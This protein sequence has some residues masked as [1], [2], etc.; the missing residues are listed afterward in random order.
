MLKKRKAY[1]IINSGKSVAIKQTKN[2]GI[3]MTVATFM[4]FHVSITRTGIDE[5]GKPIYKYVI[6]TPDR[7]RFEN[8]FS[9]SVEGV[10]KIEF[11]IIEVLQWVCLEYGNNDSSLFQR[12]NTLQMEFAKS[13][14][15]AEY[16]MYLDDAEE[17]LRKETYA[18]YYMD[19]NAFTRI[20][21]FKE[22][23]TPLVILSTK[24]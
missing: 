5:Y 4:N 7:T 8:Q 17:F 15:C 22:I 18:A 9:P 16:S 14:E 3:I 12:Y 24:D 11:A 1:G 19:D 2:K 10:K 21:N 13:P 6:L 23:E 20:I